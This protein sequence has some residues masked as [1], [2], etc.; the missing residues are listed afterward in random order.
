MGKPRVVVDS[1]R[2]INSGVGRVSQWLTNQLAPRL[3]EFADV[4]HLAQR[5]AR[6]GYQFDDRDILE[7][8]ITP[9]SRDDFDQLPELLSAAGFDLYVNPN[10]TWSPLHKTPTINMVHDLWTIEHSEWLPTETELRSRFGFTDVSLGPQLTGW[11]ESVDTASYLTREGQDLWSRR[12]DAGI[13]PLFGAALAQFGVLI[14]HSVATVAVSAQL[15]ERLRRYF[16]NAD[17]VLPIHNVPMEFRTSG[18]RRRCHFLTLAK[19]EPRKNLGMLLE[20]YSQYAESLHDRALALVIAGDSGYPTT[21]AEFH[22]RLDSMR[23][24]GMDVRFVESASDNVLASLLTD[25]AAVVN[26]SFSE[27]VGLPVLEAMLAGVPVISTATGVLDSDLRQHA[28]I[29]HADDPAG[30]CEI[31]LRV[32]MKGPP[33]RQ[34][35][36]AKRAV[37]RLV[38]EHDAEA[39]WLDLIRNALESQRVSGS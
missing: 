31:L 14:R 28:T 17:S 19:V 24:R 1:R 7:T 26:T 6:R 15:R 3:S 33:R 12:R 11:F 10:G 36:D 13:S 4:T 18:K 37:R 23:F 16:V 22:A 32:T 35:S 29:I 34:L 5:E 20:A 21:A 38:A 9:F 8:E 39:R 27:S 25:A 30:L 2:R